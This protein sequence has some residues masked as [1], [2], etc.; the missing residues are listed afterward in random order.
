MIDRNAQA[1][2]VVGADPVEALRALQ[3]NVQN[4]LGGGANIFQGGQDG[5]TQPSGSVNPNPSAGPDDSAFTDLLNQLR[6]SQGLGAINPAGTPVHDIV[7]G[8]PYAAFQA[9]QEAQ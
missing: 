8:D 5:S 9:Y 2:G 3:A 4:R 7:G 6:A 1:R